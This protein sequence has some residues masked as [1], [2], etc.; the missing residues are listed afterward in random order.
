MLKLIIIDDDG[1]IR[2][3]LSHTIRWEEL[4]IE[5]IGT[6]GDGE[7]GLE[8]IEETEPHIIIAD[9]RMPIMDGLTLTS[10][11]KSKYPEMKVILMTGYDELEFAKEALKMKVFDYLLKPVD[12]QNLLDTVQRAAA[13]WNRDHQLKLKLLEGIPLLKQ[14]FFERLIRGK[15]S[16]ENLTFQADMLDLN[17]NYDFYMTVILKA[18]DYAADHSHHRFGREMLKYCIENVAEEIIAREQ[19]GF[20]FESIDDEIIV[21]FAW[22]GP[23]EHLQSRAFELTEE[24]RASVELYLKT[25]V[26]AGMGF[27]YGQLASVTKSYSDAK[28]ALEIR[29]IIGKNQVISIQDTGLPLSPQSVDILDLEK[30]LTLKVKLGLEKDAEQVL[31]Q[32]EAKLLSAR[33]ITLQQVKLKALETAVLIYADAD[34]RELVHEDDFNRLTELIHQK[35]TVREVFAEIRQMVALLANAINASREN[36]QKEIVKQA[37][38]F[39]EQNYMRERLSLQDVA[40]EVHI[41]PTYLS[42][43]F[44]KEQNI[45]FSDYLLETRMK[46]AM[47][48]LRMKDL[49]SYEVAELVGYSNAQYFSTCF[50]KYAGCSP[51]AFKGDS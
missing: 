4:D 49:K 1:L 31:E 50:K 24:I 47:E 20:V 8:L 30:A 5:L 10:I 33:S 21:L 3:G 41:S 11:V 32:I 16:E 17:F 7:R 51:S 46:V 12:N 19:A 26:T 44:K 6:A 22:K 45:N 15:L 40:D 43:I 34:L 23:D 13:E 29:H 35:Q 18:D 39:I 42:Y 48:L 2:R 14:R 37:M 28:S 36:Q 25:T 27:L 9:I 38:D